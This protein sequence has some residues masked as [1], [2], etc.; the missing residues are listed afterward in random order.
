MTKKHIILIGGFGNNLFQLN[1]VFNLVDAGFKVVV[2]SYFTSKKSRWLLRLSGLSFHNSAYLIEKFQLIEKCDKVEFKNTLNLALIVTIFA[3]KINAKKKHSIYYLDSAINKRFLVYLR[4]KIFYLRDRV[5]PKYIN[6]NV[7]HVRGG[8]FLDLGISMKIDIYNSINL[9]N[10]LVVTDDIG[11][12]Q[13]LFKNHSDFEIIS[14]DSFRDFLIMVNARNLYLSNSTFSW[15][16]AE[17]SDSCIKIYQPAVMFDNRQ[18]NM[19]TT[20]RRILL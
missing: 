11:Y 17:I 7:L 6:R 15:W 5:N 2:H 10:L 8:D 13:S 16:A 14:K 3:S 9:D 1:E 20:K 19:Q 18:M 4:K 12:A